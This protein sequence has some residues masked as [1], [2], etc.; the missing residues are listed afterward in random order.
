MLIRIVFLVNTLN[1]NFVAYNYV[2]EI[3]IIFKCN[4]YVNKKFL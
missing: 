3:G 2:G 1:D 4:L